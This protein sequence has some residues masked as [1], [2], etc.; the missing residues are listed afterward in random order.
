MQAY[1]EEIDEVWK[2][3]KVGSRERRES[4]ST[5]HDLIFREWK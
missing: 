2:V 4:G 3:R 1:F 5:L